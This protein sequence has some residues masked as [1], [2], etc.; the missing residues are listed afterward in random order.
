MTIDR[1]EGIIAIHCDLCPEYYDPTDDDDKQFGP[2]VDDF[3][4]VW[5]RA[6]QLGWRASKQANGDWVHSCPACNGVTG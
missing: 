3:H 2:A 5:G 4:A 1:G 6:K